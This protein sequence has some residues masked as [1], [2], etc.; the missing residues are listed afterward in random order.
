[1]PPKD[2]KEKPKEKPS[3]WDFDP[4]EG[5]VILLLFIAIAGSLLTILLNYFA[6][7]DISFYGYKL[8]NIVDF[9]RSNSL[10]FKILGYIVSGAAAIGTFIFIK[11]GDSIWREEKAKLYP[12]NIPIVSSS[13][14]QV[15][16]QK[17]EKWEKIIKL[18]ES[19]SSSDWR[20]S[21][22]EADVM[23]GEL[24]EKLG[25]PGET[26]GERLKAVEKSDFTTIEY[27]WEAH[28][29]RNVIAHG[30]NDFLINQREIR[31]IISLYEAV[32]K[33][34]FLI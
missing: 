14:G 26:M 2:K 31:R 29:F 9:F 6:S 21:I 13:I 8:S 20:L 1:M 30:G 22:I 19:E 34:F 25:L 28:K 27:A 3:G 7:G 5:I 10:L 11:K 24:L 18:S 33:E 17:L 16:N 4:I 23:L 12:K 32:F 15:K